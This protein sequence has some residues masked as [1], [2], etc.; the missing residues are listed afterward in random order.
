MLQASYTAPEL[1]VRDTHA[2][3]DLVSLAIPVKT[4]ILFTA[5]TL[6]EEEM[7]T[8]TPPYRHP[9]SGQ[10]AFLSLTYGAFAAVFALLGP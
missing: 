5:I 9:T 8:H 3:T 2:L 7:L 1:A 4:F 6:R 10:L